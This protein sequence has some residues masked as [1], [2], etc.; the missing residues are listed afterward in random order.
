MKK[1]LNLIILQ[2]FFFGAMAQ[3]PANKLQ[4]PLTY[5]DG[6]GPYFQAMAGLSWD[7]ENPLNSWF[8][9]YKDI[10]GIPPSWTAVKKGII[11]FDIRQFAYQNYATGNISKDFYIEL[12]NCWNWKPDTTLLSK[13]PINCFV[14]VVRGKNSAGKQ[15]LVVDSQGNLDVADDTPFEPVKHPRASTPPLKETIQVAYQKLIGGKVT[16]LKAPIMLKNDSSML[17]FNIPRHAKAQFRQNGRNY[18]LNISNDF[19]SDDFSEARITLAQ[20]KITTMQGMDSISNKGEYITIGKKIYRNNGVI[21]DRLEL[22]E[23]T[24]TLENVS[25]GVA[26]IENKYL[27]GQRTHTRAQTLAWFKPYQGSLSKLRHP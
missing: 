18:D 2:F 20:N 15:M 5:V 1:Y 22:E 11:F 19:I 13:T 12:Q 25:S 23:I 6:Y 21:A 27:L 26:R 9:T 16:D 3:A 17:W 7:D 4:L 24:D 8:K 14:Y 10:K